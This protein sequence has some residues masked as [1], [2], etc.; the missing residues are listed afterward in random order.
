MITH[1]FDSAGTPAD[2]VQKLAPLQ[3][4]SKIKVINSG[5]D[6]FEGNLYFTFGE[7]GQI[8]TAEL[9]PENDIHM[10]GVGEYYATTM[11][12]GNVMYLNADKI[13][14]KIIINQEAA[15]G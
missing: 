3:H 14:V 8:E 1:V 6:V 2:W 9:L 11:K 13:G 7:P 15:N 5:D 12:A 10:V 4:D